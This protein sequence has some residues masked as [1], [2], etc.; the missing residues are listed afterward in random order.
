MAQILYLPMDADFDDDSPSGHAV[1]KNGANYLLTPSNMTA[2]NSP[3]P[4]VVTH[5]IS[6]EPDTNWRSWYPFDAYIGTSPVGHMGWLINP[7]ESGWI[8]IDL[9]VKHTIYKY[10]LYSTNHNACPRDWTLKG[11]NTGSFSGEET[12][13]DTR[14]DIGNWGADTY[15]EYTIDSS[16]RLRYIRL[17]ITDWNSA[18]IGIGQI[19]LYGDQLPVIDNDIYDTGSGSGLFF[20]SGGN[21]LSVSKD[22]GFEFNDYDFEIITKVRF[23][24]LPP[25]TGQFYSF[26]SQY[27]NDGNRWF[28]YLWNSSGTYKLGFYCRNSATE[29]VALNV[30]WTPTLDTWY[31][32]KFSREGTTFHIYVDDSDKT[33]TGKQIGSSSFGSYSSAVVVA[34]YLFGYIL[35]F[36]FDGWL[37]DIETNID[38]GT[39]YDISAT[40]SLQLSDLLLRKDNR[41]HPTDSLVFSDSLNKD[42]RLHPTDSLAFSDSLSKSIRPVKSESLALSDS[43][44][45]FFP[46]GF[47]I[48]DS[49]SLSDSLSKT[50]YVNLPPELG[51]WY[52]FNVATGLWEVVP[53]PF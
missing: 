47:N 41:F 44:S 53:A 34:S 39:T 10:R 46:A 16:V 13:L 3:S 14:A 8:Q 17:N 9:G 7:A 36:H 49:I 21:Y 29:I 32:L 40:D 26:I 22:S 15:V 33:L 18:Y 50:T 48:S 12:T 43:L 25:T 37:D 35:P 28:A 24:S 51:P 11:S 4:F 23:R 27:Y 42:N 30:D 6:T 31:K 38:T 2:D 45:K 5:S 20:S 19:Q 52:Y 1:T